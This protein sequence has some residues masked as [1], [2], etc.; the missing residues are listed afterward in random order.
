MHM[1]TDEIFS[2]TYL[3]LTLAGKISKTVV[4]PEITTEMDCDEF[5]AAVVDGVVEER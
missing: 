3:V 2:Y 5:S 1:N 4:A